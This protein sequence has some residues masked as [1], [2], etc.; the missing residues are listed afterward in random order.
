MDLHHNIFYSYRGPT[1]DQA[2]R[3]RQVENNVTKAL[4]NT[5]CLGGE[6]VWRPFLLE[7][8]ITEPAHASF[9]LQGEDIPSGCAAHRRQRVLLGISKDSSNWV[10]VDGVEG[11]YSSVPDAWIYGDG[12]AVLVESKVVGDFSNGQM[13]S[14][15]EKLSPDKPRQ[16]QI[17]LRTWRDIHRL[18]RGLLSNL[19]GESRLLMKQFIQF[20]EYSDMT[21]FTGFQRDSL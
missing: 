3:E 17:V 1:P 13:L 2:G 10:P 5:L 18:F 11:A 20:L 6:E 15:L 21:G 8:G 7:L 9:L 19:T 4:I 14:H 12:F 16:A